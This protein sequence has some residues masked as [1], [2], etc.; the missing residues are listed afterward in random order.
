MSPKMEQKVKLLRL[1]NRYRQIAGH[2]YFIRTE[3]SGLR[4]TK[5]VFTE[6]TSYSLDSA[7]TAMEEALDALGVSA[8]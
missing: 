3:P 1:N 6:G 2:P 5:W 4:G 7:V 8:R